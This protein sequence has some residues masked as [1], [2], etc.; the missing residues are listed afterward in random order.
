[1]DALLR[2]LKAGRDGITEYHDVELTG[3]ELAIGAGADQ[4]IQ[5]LGRSVAPAHAVIRKSGAALAIE[6]RG[7]NRVHV[8]DREVRTAR[9]AIGDVI[10]LAGHRLTLADAPAGFD[11]AIELQ[12][13]ES[14]DASEF[15][16]A[17]RT[18]LRQTWLGQRAIAWWSVVLVVVLGLA[19]PLTMVMLKRSE[20][21]APSWVPSDALWSSGPLHAAHSQ[22]VGERCDT[23]HRQLF[24]RVQ[25][26]ACRDCHQ[27]INDHIVP[28]HLAQTKLGLA[29]RCA[30]CHREHDEPQSFLVNQSDALCI[31]CHA[32]S[33]RDFGA[34]KVDVVSGFGAQTHP[35]FKAHVLKPKTLANAQI[36]AFEWITEIQALDQAKEQSNLRFSHVQHLDPDRVL[37]TS[38]SQPLACADCHRL[39]PDGEH[40]APMAMEKSCASC[41]ELTFDPAAPDRQL[42]HGKPREVVLTL[43]DYFTRKFSDPNAAR[44]TR[45]RRRLPGHE[46][47][48]TCTGAPFD[49]AMRSART[50]IENQF[51]RRG[52][53]G[54]HVVVDTQTEDVFERFQVY[55]IRFARDYFPAARFDH[56]S[57][58]IQNKL[59]GDAACLS[60][61]AANKSEDSADLM[62]PNLA[63]CEDCHGD[64]PALERV[65]VQCVSCHSYHAH[66]RQ[67]ERLTA[68]AEG[69]GGE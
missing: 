2:E 27:T 6:C 12:P 55:P 48:Q 62:L 13:N 14:I 34:L 28:E 1:M 68:I 29:Q 10:T 66:Q 3:R 54:C 4:A 22:A 40:F 15:E 41:H 37:R 69:A 44:A 65:T 26:A 8:N 24:E 53:V 21:A 25:D 16:S 31:D 60:C 63:K 30:S 33:Q 42:P 18:D 58:Q 43:Q 52:C 9:L 59:T 56:R 46:E 20:R 32:D 11:V 51:S 39:E 49:C 23:C 50:E 5:L 7:A 19:L 57:H 64:R 36:P 35:A 17:F 38:D 47:E 67:E 61:H 45:E